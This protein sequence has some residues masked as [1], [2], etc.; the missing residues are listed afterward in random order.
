MFLME[1]SLVNG[2][3]DS[4]VM[5]KGKL[6][7]VSPLAAPAT[8]VIVSN[9]PLFIKDEVL[10][11]ELSRFG[12]F[13]SGFKPISLRCRSPDLKHVLSLQRQVL[14]YL[15]SPEPTLN[16]NFYVKHGDSA[17]AVYATSESLLF[18]SVERLDISA[19]PVQGGRRTLGQPRTVTG[20]QENEEPVEGEREVTGDDLRGGDQAEWVETRGGGVD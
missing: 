11:R 9:V 3:L 20:D 1:E 7:A 14:M 19:W 6:L 2:L 5:V 4:G 13:A 12:K 10:V 8:R 16:V 17:Y 15:K 18:L